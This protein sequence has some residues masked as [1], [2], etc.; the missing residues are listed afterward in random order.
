MLVVVAVLIV[1]LSG[2]P[3]LNFAMIRAGARSFLQLRNDSPRFQCSLPTF[4]EE[5]V[6]ATYLILTNSVNPRFFPRPSPIDA[7][8]LAAEN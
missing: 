4:Y 3:P 7:P 2:V 8:P 6:L 1:S 5:D